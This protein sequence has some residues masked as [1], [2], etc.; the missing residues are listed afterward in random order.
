MAL[1]P[2]WAHLPLSSD[3]GHTEW[4]YWV[5]DPRTYSF[6]VY[7]LKDKNTENSSSGKNLEAGYGHDLNSPEQERCTECFLCGQ[8]CYRQQRHMSEPNDS[9]LSRHS[10]SNGGNGRWW[11]QS[12]KCIAC[13]I[14]QMLRKLKQRE[15]IEHAL[16]Y[17]VLKESLSDKVPC[18][19]GHDG[20]EHKRRKNL[21]IRGS[22]KYKGPGVSEQGCSKNSKEASG[23]GTK[24]VRG[25][26][27]GS[28][29]SPLTAGILW[30]I[31]G[32]LWLA[33]AS[34]WA[35]LSPNFLFL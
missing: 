25:R 19:Q 16:L 26:V 2:V 32:I 23:S 11:S 20:R 1:P 18:D 10:C 13:Q 31:I 5:S 14:V 9:L 7:I 12:N 3:E 22:S 8:L 35:C 17:R 28:P 24:G 27:T 15:E 4:E 21:L 29:A 33:E 6:I 34:P 30:A